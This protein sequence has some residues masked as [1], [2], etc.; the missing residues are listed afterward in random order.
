MK[1]INQAT[2]RP[3]RKMAAV[4][5]TSLLGPIVA[6]TIAPWLP[7]LS[8]ACGGEVGASLAAGGLALA[9]GAVNFVAGYVVKE[10]E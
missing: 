9:Q 1:L 6:A 2:L 8:E 10:R 5:W 3:T 7:G 4:G